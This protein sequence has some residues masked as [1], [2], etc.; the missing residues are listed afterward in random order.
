[1]LPQINSKDH[2]VTGLGARK[3]FD[4]MCLWIIGGLCSRSGTVLDTY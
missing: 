2:S 1:M 4:K 3:S